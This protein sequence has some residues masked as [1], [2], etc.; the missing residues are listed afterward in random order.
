MKNW[1]LVAIVAGLALMFTSLTLASSQTYQD[2]CMMM[3]PS[4]YTTLY[5]SLPTVLSAA[6]ALL[7]LVPIVFF[8]QDRFEG[9]AFTAS[10]IEVESDPGDLTQPESKSSVDRL[11]VAERLLDEDERAVLRIIAGNEGITQDSLH[12]RTGFSTSKVSAIVKKLE[13]KDLIYRE[14]FGKTYRLYLSDWLKN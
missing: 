14:R 13:G 6:G 5:T 8:V 9:E 1:H 2:Q 10:E 4:A 12:F 3:R 7:V 11:A